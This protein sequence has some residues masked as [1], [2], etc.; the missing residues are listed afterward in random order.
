MGQSKPALPL[1]W[2]YMGMVEA[3]GPANTPDLEKKQSVCP[4]GK[5]ELSI[6]PPRQMGRKPPQ[7]FGVMTT[8][9]AKI[10]IEIENKPAKPNQKNTSS[11]LKCCISG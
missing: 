7:T 1:P 5:V 3:K 8:A 11:H 9:N 4:G 10:I 2:I 6:F